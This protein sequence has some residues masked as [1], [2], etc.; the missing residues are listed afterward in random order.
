[1]QKGSRHVPVRCYR[2]CPH[3]PAT[4]SP[5]SLSR[6]RDQTPSHF[7]DCIPFQW[8][9]RS[10]LRK[11]RRQGSVYVWDLGIQTF[12]FL[13]DVLY[14]PYIYISSICMHCISSSSSRR[15]ISSSIVHPLTITLRPF[16]LFFSQPPPLSLTFFFLLQWTNWKFAADFLT[17]RYSSK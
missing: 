12:S 9:K 11:C 6:P 4:C 14:L 10:K 1:M 8:K 3:P 16:S 7:H 13:S 5:S 2:S 15:S 17:R